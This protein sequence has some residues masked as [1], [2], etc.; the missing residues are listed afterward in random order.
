MAGGWQPGR[1]RARG[2]GFEFQSFR[3]RFGL[4][5]SSLA[6]YLGTRIAFLGV[7]NDHDEMIVWDSKK[8]VKNAGL[9]FE[10]E[11]VQQFEIAFR[12]S[13]VDSGIHLVDEFDC[14]PLFWKPDVVDRND[15]SAWFQELFQGI[16]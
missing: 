11:A 13:D 4:R 9:Y 15:S 1:G 3:R 8:V 5:A 12:S 7:A 10:S 16:K 2:I 14:E 6:Q